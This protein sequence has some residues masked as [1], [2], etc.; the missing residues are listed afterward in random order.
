VSAFFFFISLNNWYYGEYA[1]AASEKGE[2]PTDFGY[3][4]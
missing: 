4:M 1:E 3:I 2:T